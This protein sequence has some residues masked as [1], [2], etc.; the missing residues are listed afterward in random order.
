VRDIYHEGVES[1]SEDAG[2]VDDYVG[3]AGLV[4][5]DVDGG[6]EGAWDLG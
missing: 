1:Y 3:E 2:E 6:E 4:G 5:G